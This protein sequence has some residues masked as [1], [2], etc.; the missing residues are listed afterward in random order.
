MTEPLTVEDLVEALSQERRSA[1]ATRLEY[2]AA[3]WPVIEADR[4]R[5]R[6]EV[7]E[8]IAQAIEALHVK[9][10]DQPVGFSCSIAIARD[11]AKEPTDG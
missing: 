9:V 8:E 2:A 11:H 1:V 5:V 6:A 3:I 4:A 7:A 10:G